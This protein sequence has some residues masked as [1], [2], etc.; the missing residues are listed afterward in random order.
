MFHLMMVT[1]AVKVTLRDAAHFNNSSFECWRTETLVK[2]NKSTE[3]VCIKLLLKGGGT[4]DWHSTVLKKD[5]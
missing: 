4:F 3:L 5:N 1:K 2:C